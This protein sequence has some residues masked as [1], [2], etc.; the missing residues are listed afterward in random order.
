MCGKE[1]ENEF[2][3][4]LIAIFTPFFTLL[5]ENEFIRLQF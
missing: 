2:V 1:V 5:V 4:F 3:Q